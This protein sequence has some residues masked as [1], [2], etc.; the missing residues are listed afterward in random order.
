MDLRPSL[1][2]LHGRHAEEMRPHAHDRPNLFC[3]SDVNVLVIDDD[4]DVCRLIKTALVGHD[5]Q[6]E[7]VSDPRE[8]EARLRSKT[9]HLIVLDY[10]IPPLQA[11]QVLEW[12]KDHQPDASI[13]VVTAYP[14]IDSALHCLRARTYDYIT[15]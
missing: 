7:S 14:S 5:F 11:E 13:I 2:A 8:I 4:E 15:K 1:A 6:V 10:V 12:L 9:F 3:S